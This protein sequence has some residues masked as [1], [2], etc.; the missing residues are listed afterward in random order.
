MS[1]W[2]DSVCLF[3]AR[4]VNF[5]GYVDI[6]FIREGN[7]TWGRWDYYLFDPQSERFVTNNL[8][9]D[10]DELRDNGLDFDWKTH[11]I[12]AP[13]LF[14]LCGGMDIYTIGKGRLIKIQEDKVR[15]ET[16]RNR[17]VETVR[18]RVGGKWRVLRVETKEIP[19]LD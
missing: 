19:R 10:L 7:G 13:F 11:E 12:R 14:G 8:T 4:D 18:R 16:E 17:C 6:F 3:E 5:D 9:H 2:N 15:I 1:N